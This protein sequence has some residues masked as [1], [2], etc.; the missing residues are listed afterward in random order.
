MFANIVSSNVASQWFNLVPPN[1]VQ[2][3]WFAG[4]HIWYMWCDMCPFW[5]WGSHLSSALK[6]TLMCVIKAPQGQGHYISNLL[7]TSTMFTIHSIEVGF[8]LTCLAKHSTRK[9]L[10]NAVQPPV[11][12]LVHRNLHRSLVVF[13]QASIDAM[14]LLQACSVPQ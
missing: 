13:H 3:F 12:F 4:S 11:W 8:V 2:A 7:I 1:V 9:T 10:H 6:S 14:P 5:R